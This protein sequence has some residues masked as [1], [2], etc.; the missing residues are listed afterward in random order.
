MLYMHL[1]VCTY[2]M[3]ICALMVN[4]N[5]FSLGQL[6]FT[7]YMD[8]FNLLVV[9]YAGV[10]LFNCILHRIID[11]IMLTLIFMSAFSKVFVPFLYRVQ[12]GKFISIERRF[13]NRH[14]FAPLIKIILHLL[15][16]KG[17]KNRIT[18]S[19]IYNIDIFDLLINNCLICPL[20]WAKHILMN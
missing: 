7:S 20:F 10:K 18:Q 19:K 3:Y 15:T 2:V 12:A 17:M 5:W 16:W 1:R 14:Q 6:T 8:V 9:H 4:L 11:V 13:Y